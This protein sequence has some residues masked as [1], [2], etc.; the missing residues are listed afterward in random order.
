MT[1][2]LEEEDNRI[3]DERLWDVGA[4]GGARQG[5]EMAEYQTGSDRN[6]AA[7]LAGLYG[8]GYQSSFNT[9][10]T[11]TRQPTTDGY[12]YKLG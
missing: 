11:T 4:F 10:A 9:T 2:K 12:L 3:R 7:L 5:V 8:Q 6:R 1:F